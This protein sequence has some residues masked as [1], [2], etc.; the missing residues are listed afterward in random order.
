MPLYSDTV[1]QSDKNLAMIFYI[2]PGHVNSSM[3][4]HTRI[5]SFYLTP[6]ILNTIHVTQATDINYELYKSVY[7]DNLVKLTDYRVSGKSDK[8]TTQPTN[9]PL[10]TF[11]CGIRHIGLKNSFEASF[12]FDNSI[13]IWDNIVLD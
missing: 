7:Q 9:I 2:I 6:G 5:C 12:G 10:L 13:K 3:L 4:A 8:K 1:D 11:E